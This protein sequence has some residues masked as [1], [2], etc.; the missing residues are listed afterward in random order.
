MD[1]R[2]NKKIKI[3]YT[4]GDLGGIGPELFYKFEKSNRDNPLFEIILIDD[5]A[6][7]KSI[8]KNIDLGQA[9]AEAGDHAFKT[10]EKASKMASN[11]EIDYLVTGPVAKESL[12][13][14]GYEF[15]GQ[16]EALA[17]INNLSSKDIEMFFILDEFRAV[18]GTRHIPLK[19]VPE[20]ISKGLDQ[21]L[22]NSLVGLKKIFNISNP[23]V[24]I[25]GLNPHAGENGMLGREELDY[26]NPVIQKYKANENLE[27]A[28]PFSADWLFAQA[29]Q[30]YLKNEKQA[31]SL[32]VACYHDQVLPVIKG[33]GGFKAINLTVGLPFV[34][35]S[36][37]HGTGFDIVGQNK[38][39][40]EGIQTCTE[41]CIS[42]KLSR[43]TDFEAKKYNYSKI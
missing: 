26:I 4:L 30:S 13:M 11:N 2:E 23:K 15:S 18:L 37:D 3:G 14:A 39:D 8:I 38:A 34:R 19:D 43:F 21:V 9:T 28:G 5:E 36:M 41:F 17:H 31:F 22:E 6:K 42:P 33:V 27:I 1:L 7:A 20:N 16:T 35:V 40:L 25:A 29:A 10:L 12:K 32:Y 24:A